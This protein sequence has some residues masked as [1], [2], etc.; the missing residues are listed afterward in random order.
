LGKVWRRRIAARVSIIDIGK[1]VPTNIATLRGE[2]GKLEGTLS[3]IKP[4]SHGPRAAPAAPPAAR[5]AKTV[6]PALG[7]RSA[8][9][10]R[11]PGQRR[12]TPK[13]QSEQAIRERMGIGER[14]ATR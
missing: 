2:R 1:R 3:A 10:E 13:P 11:E 9:T 6:E 12:E 7:K 8:A 5:R 14:E 4:R